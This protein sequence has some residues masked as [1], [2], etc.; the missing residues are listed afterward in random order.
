MTRPTDRSRRNWLRGAA[1]LGL[2]ARTSASDGRPV[3]CRIVDAATGRPLPARIRLLD[4]EGREVVPAG[5]PSALDEKAQEGDVRFQSRRFAYVDGAFELDPR[6]LPLRYLVVKGFEYAM[7]EGEIT[8]SALKAGRFTIP[9]SRWAALPQKSWASGDVHIHHI[10]PKTCRLEMDAED[11]NIAN[12]LTSDFTA[13]QSRFEGRPSGFSS[14]RRVVYVNQEF[15]QDQL[16]HLCLLNLK[17]LVE[18]VQPIRHEHYPML[19]SVCDQTHAQGGYVSWAHFPSWPGLESPL[20]AA[21]EKLDGVELLC[22]L[23]PRDLPIFMKQVVPDLAANHG[24]RLWYRYLNCGF[25]LTA[26]AGTDKM[27]NFVTVG[28]NR[29]YARL[30]GEFGY[31][32]WIEALR[33]GRTFVTNCPLLEF[34]V[35]GSEA[36]AT[37]ALEGARPAVARIHARAES[38]LPYDR[39]EIVSNGAVIAEATPSGPRNTAEIRLEHPVGRSC[40][41][42]A[43]AIE[44]LSSYRARSLNFATVHIAQGTRHGDYFGTRRPETVFAHSSP[45]Y[46]IRGGQPIRSWDD[47]QY[48]VRYLDQVIRWVETEGRFASPSHKKAAI[49][50]FQAGRAIYQW[51]AAEAN[52]GPPHQ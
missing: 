2:G 8:A 12:I 17:R 48:Y 1:A 49:E 21:L 27:T 15:R 50:A 34:T 36:G 44:D 25:R 39:L 6:T 28:A 30:E 3:P 35:N 31:Q 13:D 24:L 40:W 33:A 45:V 5:H 51:R 18:P 19:V 11:L 16:G 29:V 4:R 52:A 41:I 32:G 7:A 22:V 14:G 43:R 23:E 26:T 47:A 37:L 9:L 46:V 10:S 20:A 38:Q 42:A